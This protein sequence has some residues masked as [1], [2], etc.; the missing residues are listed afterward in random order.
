MLYELFLGFGSDLGASGSPRLETLANE[1]WSLELLF[2]LI[3]AQGVPLA[4]TNDQNQFGA[5][6]WAL[7]VTFFSAPEAHHRWRL[8]QITRRAFLVA[9][10]NNALE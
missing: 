8:W 4:L 10:A 6:F 3:S 9:L 5:V 7:Q 2:A 1:S